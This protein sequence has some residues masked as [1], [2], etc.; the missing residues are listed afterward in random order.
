MENYKQNIPNILTF[1]RI[2]LVPV[3]VLLYFMESGT[4]YFTAGVFALAALTDF[5]DGLLSRK[6]KATSKFGEMMDPIADKLIV[7]AALALL[8][9]ENSALIIPAIGIMCRE[10]FVSGLREFLAKTEV[11]LPVTKISKLK[12]VMQ[13]LSISILLYIPSYWGEMGLVLKILFY[14]GFALL[15]AAFLLTLYTGYKYYISARE[16]G[17]I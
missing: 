8:I 1:S 10:I 7:V 9:E 13:L 2:A 14:F 4:K 11:E 6:W 16:K 17:L 5:F 12:T 3:L 15:W